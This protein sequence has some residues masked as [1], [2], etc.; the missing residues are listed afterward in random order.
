VWKIHLH[1]PNENW[2]S[3]TRQKKIKKKFRRGQRRGEKRE[4]REEGWRERITVREGER[5]KDM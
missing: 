1:A 4:R 2:K 3:L 5:M